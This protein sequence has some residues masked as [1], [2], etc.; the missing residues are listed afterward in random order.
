LFWLSTAKREETRQKRLLEIVEKAAI[1]KK[2]NFPN[3]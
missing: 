3:Q 1:N 2:A